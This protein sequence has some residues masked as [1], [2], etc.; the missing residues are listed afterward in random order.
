MDFDKFMVA[1]GGRY[2]IVKQ[3]FGGLTVS[4]FL[5]VPRDTTGKSGNADWEMPSKGPDAGGKYT[6]FTTVI[7][8][9]VMFAF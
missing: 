1:V 7:N 5:Y 8:A 3:M 4:Q 9:N 6:Q 2:R